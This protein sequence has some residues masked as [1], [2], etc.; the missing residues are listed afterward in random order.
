MYDSAWLVFWDCF[1]IWRYLAEIHALISLEVREIGMAVALIIRVR[2]FR[3]GLLLD[4]K[5]YV[6]QAVGGFLLITTCGGSPASGEAEIF[7]LF[8]QLC[9]FRLEGVLD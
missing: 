9:K 7:S 6:G 3:R 8:T 2:D 1:F 4:A 5:E